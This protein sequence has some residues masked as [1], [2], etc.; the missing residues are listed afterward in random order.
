[1]KQRL[2]SAV[3][4]TVALT[5]WLVCAVGSVRPLHADGRAALG[6]R[7][8]RALE[9]ARDVAA[10]SPGDRADG[11]RTDATWIVWVHLRDKGP[12]AAKSGVRQNVVSE[13]SLR[14]RAK[15]RPPDQLVDEHDL[16]LYATYVD[17]V[18]ERVTRVRQRSKWLNA[19]SVE[20]TRA[21]IDALR[22]VEG[23]REIELVYRATLRHDLN[24]RELDPLP[25]RP[26]RFESPRPSVPAKPEAPSVPLRFEYGLSLR[27]LEI[28]NITLM[29]SLGYDGGGVI[30]GHF[31]NGHRLL[32]HEVFERLD[33]LG[34]RDFIDND[35][36][37]A[38]D[39]S[40]PV[41]FG[42]HGIATLSVLAGFKE[43]RII[44]PA[45]ASQYL[46]ART[47]NDAAESPLEEDN[48]VA[49]VEWADSMGVDITSTSLGYLE[50]E[51]G[52]P[53]WT[54]A[55]MD[56]NTTVITRAADL[57]ASR[58]IVVVNAVGN[59]GLRDEPNTLMAPADGREVISVGAVNDDGVRAGFTSYG[60]TVDGRTKPDVLAHGSG[61]AIA[62]T[63]NEAA[64][65]FGG[66]TSLSAPLVAG[67]AAILLQAYPWATPAQIRDALR[68]TASRADAVDRFEGW[69]VIDA[70]AAFLY[71]RDIGPPPENPF[72][73]RPAYIV[74]N[75]VAVLPTGA[76][77]YK[78]DHD[79][80]V[81]LQVFDVRG[82][83]VR[84]LL[85]APRSADVHVTTWDGRDDRGQ[86]AGSGIFFVRLHTR[87][88][89]APASVSTATAKLLRLD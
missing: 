19:L 4:C 48:W 15:V 37:T 85:S 22:N 42:A 68:A 71:L 30:I 26:P 80:H 9:H 54:W 81:T 73:G 11:I 47:E 67:T 5:A 44:G 69:G 7:L 14:R 74:P 75:V 88:L 34:M 61:T 21:Q 57:A 43:T 66:G 49:A 28:S 76:I 51:D 65:G 50:F 70:Y 63:G 3:V 55:D 53:D 87:A 6:P 46:L 10:R 2:S 72:R 62:Q 58:G 25:A 29:H 36:D 41:I 83:R 89:D 84:Q 86:L 32:S 1:M 12:H 79:A 13:R 78:L 18:A 82:R 24:V 17:A 8:A 38:P 40:D 39:P 60:P 59:I 45:F 27:Q 35:L 77:R 20:A 33:V 64:Y 56:G 31:D 16:P 23:V 52:F